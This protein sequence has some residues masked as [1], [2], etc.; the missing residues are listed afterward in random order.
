MELVDTGIIAFNIESGKVL[1]ANDSFNKVLNIPNIKNIEFIKKRNPKIFR[2]VFET[3][4]IKG[5]TISIDS[6]TDKTK[7]LISNSS[8]MVKDEKFKLVVLQNI[9]NT[10]NQNQAEAWN[11]LL[12]VMTHE[13]MNSIA[14][15]SS[16]AET[17]Q[18]KIQSS[19]E[20]PDK[21]EIDT[22]DL[23]LGI[24]SIR[25][26]SE[27]LMKFANTYRGLNKIDNLNLSNTS[28]GVLFESISNL[29]QPSLSSKNIEMQ[30]NLDNPE[31][32]IVMDTSLIE[33]VLINLIKNSIE[34]CK[35]VENQLIKI[36]AEKNIEGIAIITV[37]DN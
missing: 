27:G 29:L 25:N 10:L 1:W 14:P 32:Q 23:Y 5:D 2:D 35:D 30:F 21:H 19:I 9:E 11:K 8:F 12:R 37:S 17:L 36:S 15:I 13:I 33:Q 4:H 26:R 24:D 34:A 31:L 18:T 20:N 22:N 16:L 28:I 3:D 6:E 7:I